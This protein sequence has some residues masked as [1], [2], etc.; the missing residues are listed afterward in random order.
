MNPKV[1]AVILNWNNYTDTIECINSLKN[2]TYKNFH[3]IIVDNFS[4]N[5][6]EAVLRKEYQE[7]KIIQTGENLGFAGGNNI[8]ID[9][10]L[11]QK[12]DYVLLLNNDT[13]VKPDFLSYIVDAGENDATVGIIGGKTYNYYDKTR[14]CSAG[15]NINWLKGTAAF[16]RGEGKIDTGEFDERS[17]I[18]FVPGYFMLVKRTVFEMTGKLDDTYFLGVEEI[19]FCVK[20]KRN[21]FNLLYIP[22]SIIWHKVTASHK[23]YLPMFIYNGYRNKLI[24][25]KR[26]LP[27]PAWILWFLLFKTYVSTIA[28]FRL[29]KVSKKVGENIKYD[30]FMKASKLAFKDR[31]KGKVTLADINQLR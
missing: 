7:Y 26:H 16:H 21:G 13:T 18:S 20:A 5:D 19:D 15:A 14:L 31:G 22:E 23:K 8:A 30:D 27:Y 28:P 2:V 10:C 9:Y 12:A 11:T 3:I 17:Y 29:K 6:S 4:D 25:M 1:F 24:F